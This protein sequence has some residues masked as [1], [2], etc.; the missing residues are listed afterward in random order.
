MG[1]NCRIVA[2]EIWPDS[3]PLKKKNKN[4]SRQELSLS[5]FMP[6][7]R[8]FAF[9]VKESVDSK[10]IIQAAKSVD[11]NLISGV[12]L[13]DVYRGNGVEKGYK[14]IAIEVILSPKLATL[15]DNDIEAVS[16][17]IITSVEKSGGLLRD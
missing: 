16:K 1:I 11:K 17:N 5:D 8:D 7:S 3:I 10:K 14:S 4:K 2:F 12:N 13:F 15:T 6:I 9:I